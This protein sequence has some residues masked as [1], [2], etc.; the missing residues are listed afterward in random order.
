MSHGLK[1]QPVIVRV[2]NFLSNYAKTM[3]SLSPPPGPS[4]FK[5]NFKCSDVYFRLIV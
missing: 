3:A 2:G 1:F 5:P 4:S